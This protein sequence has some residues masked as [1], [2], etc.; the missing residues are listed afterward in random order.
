MTLDIDFSKEDE[1]EALVAQFFD[2]ADRTVSPANVLE[3]KPDLT[4]TMLQQR[5]FWLRRRLGR[6][7]SHRP[8]RNKATPSA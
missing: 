6:K 2:A 1:I 3:P 5:E 7:G 4:F 8:I